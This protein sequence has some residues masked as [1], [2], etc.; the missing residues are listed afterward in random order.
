MSSILASKKYIYTDIQANN[1]KFWNIDRYDDHTVITRWGRV[2]DKEQSKSFPHGSETS[3]ITFFN[4]KC[5]EKSKKGYTEQRTIESNTTVKQ[6]TVASSNLESIAKRQIQTNSPELDALIS[7]LTKANIHSIVANSN[8][9]YN[10]TTGLFS[11]PLGI[12]DEDAILEARELLVSINSIVLNRDFGN[13]DFAGI[14][15]KYFRIVPTVIG[16]YRQEPQDLFPNKETVVKQNDLLDSLEVSLQT[17]KAT[18]VTAITSVEPEKNIF[19]VKLHVVDD[20]PVIQRITAK[21]QSTMNRGHQCSHLG[22]KR[23]YELEIGAMKTAFEN[24]GKQIGGIQELWHG[25]RVANILS[26]LYK[27][28]IIPPSNSSFV[29][30]RLFGDGLYFA[31]QSTKSLNYSY[32]YWD[33]KGKDENC[34]MFLCDVAMGKHY[35]PKYLQSNIPAGYD[36]FWAKAGVSGVQNDEIIVPRLYQANPRYLIEFS[37]GGR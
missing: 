29:A 35:T 4:Q 23:V 3:A 21:Y 32:G 30:G 2:G 22:V 24:K 25:S 10:D 16:R 9:S 19:N 33:A 34:F 6:T 36:S 8:I 27:G 31:N 18:P 13:K 28:M 26:I 37:P 17:A 7:R 11:T 1:N 14:T 5:S 12:I 15:N 20:L